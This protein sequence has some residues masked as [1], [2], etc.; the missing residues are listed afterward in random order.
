MVWGFSGRWWSTEWGQMPALVSP[1]LLGTVPV[2]YEGGS[3]S[4]SGA[5]HGGP[6]HLLLGGVSR[7]L[8]AEPRPQEDRVLGTFST[9][10][11]PG[12]KGWQAVFSCGASSEAA[13]TKPSVHRSVRQRGSQGPWPGLWTSHSVFEQV[14]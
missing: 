5:W 2:S 9:E 8:Q 11:Q 6:S 10:P 1:L 12:E 7:C 3:A 13:V 4:V 14:P